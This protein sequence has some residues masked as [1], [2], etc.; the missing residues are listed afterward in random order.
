MVKACN[1]AMIQDAPELPHLTDRQERILALIVREYVSRPDPVSSKHLAETELN[2]SSAT[3][4]NDMAVLEELGFVLSPHTSAGRIPTEAGYRYFV[5]RL[6]NEIDLSTDEQR[7]ITDQF[8]T[9]GS[10]LQN[11]MRLAVATL[12]RTS[13]AGAL[14]TTPRASRLSQ[15]K[16][17]ELIVTQG[18]LVL[19]VLVLYGGQVRQQMLTL[20]EALPQEI[21]STVA[22]RL[23]AICDLLDADQVRAR[24][25]SFD[26]PLEREVIELIADTMR[27]ADDSQ[28]AIVYQDGLR[29]ML[30]EF[31]EQAAAQ[32]ALRVL[33]EQSLIGAIFNEALGAD[34]GGVQV[35]IGGEG[36]WSEVRHLSL[37]LA[38][39]GAGEQ[40]SGL[41][42]V[43]G[44]T[45]MRYG[46]AIA[47]VR[48]IAGLMSGLLLD[49]Y[50]GGSGTIGPTPNSS[51]SLGL[52]PP[53]APTGD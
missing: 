29:E 37:V 19:M 39:Y 47:S 8:R 4:R 11:W 41:L 34:V 27:I 12:S 26:A 5:K 36:R 13:H 42:G 24:G 50:N 52:K 32:Q 21:L 14:V 46:R 15:F 23:N 1:L 6:L 3:I 43:I 31:S 18:R 53:G 38:R 2:V 22:A 49:V 9:S 7:Q 16:H 45:R 44:P 28:H 33:E 48:F 30:P 10:D 20:A 17:V 40:S 25:R 35:V 51:D